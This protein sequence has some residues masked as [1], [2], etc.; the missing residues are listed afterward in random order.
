[1]KQ[2]VRC[3][4]LLTFVFSLASMSAMAQNDRTLELQTDEGQI[5]IPLEESVPLRLLGDGDVTATALS[6]FTC[7]TD[8]PSCEDVQVSLGAT[9]GGGF[10][11]SPNPVELGSNVSINWTGV[12]AWEC[13]GTGLPGTTWNSDN[14]KQPTGQQSVNTGALQA[15]QSYPLEVICSNGPVTDSR[16]ISLAVD[17]DTGPP[18]PQGCEDVPA[19]GDSA[20]WAPASS[21]LRNNSTHDPEV[22]EDI[23]GE[24]FPG[25]T[26]TAHFEIRKGQYA[27]IRFRTPEVLDSTEFGQFNS[28]SAGQVYPGGDRRLVSISQCPGV[29]DPQYL[30]DDD[31]I[32]SLNLTTPMYWRGPNSSDAAFRCNLEPDTTYYLNFIYSRSDV[33]DFPPEQ[34]PCEAGETHCGS[35]MYHSSTLQ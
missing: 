20:G 8:G 1:M 14:P 24:P 18:P 22:F 35:L 5:D 13:E 12:G 26:N 16:T 17:E 25:T 33:G 4:A 30:A 28:V 21:I 34:A 2:Q 11:V 19:L 23:F 6:G 7:P 3:T 29:F 10:A 27:A 15:D 32:Q 9:D 31:C